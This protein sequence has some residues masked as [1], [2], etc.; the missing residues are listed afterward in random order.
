MPR[1]GGA[2]RGACRRK[3]RATD[4]RARPGMAGG[5]ASLYARRPEPA[6][7]GGA[8]DEVQDRILRC[9]KLRTG[10][11]PCEG[12]VLPD[13][14][15]RDRAGRGRGRRVRDRHRRQ[16][17]LFEEGDRPFPDAG[18]SRVDCGGCLKANIRRARSG[19][20]DQRALFDVGDFAPAESRGAREAVA[21]IS[22]CCSTSAIPRRGIA[23]RARS[24]RVGV[25][26]A[27]HRPRA[28][29]HPV[30]CRDRQ[31]GTCP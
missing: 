14:R 9:L 5:T 31:G 25:R 6:A 3:H 17:R 12:Q 15:G 24:G 2:A 19:R 30:R 8:P 20:V 16:A 28:R 27:A 7:S 4:W 22:G 10:S 29:S 21:S 18:R 23:G 11:P 26:R 1:A 13:R